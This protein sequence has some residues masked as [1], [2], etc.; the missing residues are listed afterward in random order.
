MESSTNLAAV[1]IEDG[2]LVVLL[3]TRSSIAQALEALRAR[4]EAIGNLAGAGVEHAN[5]YPGWQPNPDSELLGITKA[6]HANLYSKAPVVEAIHAGLETG[7]IGEKFPGMDM[8]S[9]GPTIKNPHSPDENIDL[10][11]VG[12]FWDWVLALL[13]RP[14]S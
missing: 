5:A 8:I 7:I 1:R 13:A 4:I 11:T 9:I 14:S 3:S 10:A 12:P 2:A 6:V